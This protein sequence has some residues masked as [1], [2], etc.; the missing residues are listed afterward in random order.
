LQRRRQNS[1]DVRVYAAVRSWPPHADVVRGMLM[2][3]VVVVVVVLVVMME[4]VGL[5][6]SRDAATNSSTATGTV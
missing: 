2:L 1:V 3:M 5:V 4:V 6:A